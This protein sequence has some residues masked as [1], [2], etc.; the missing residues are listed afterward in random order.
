ME[1]RGTKAM[2]FRVRAAVSGGTR[3]YAEIGEYGKNVLP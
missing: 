2:V 1:F 3:T